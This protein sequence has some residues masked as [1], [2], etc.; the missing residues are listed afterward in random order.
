MGVLQGLVS[1]GAYLYAAWKG[2]PD[3]D[4]I[5]YS[6]WNGTGKWAA[7]GRSLALPVPVLP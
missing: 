3:D 1:N 5:F 6:R 2:E 7:Q 4:R